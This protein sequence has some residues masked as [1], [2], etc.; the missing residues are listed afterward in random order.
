MEEKAGSA[1][2]GPG[3]IAGIPPVPAAAMAGFP[4]THHPPILPQYR[5]HPDLHNAAPLLCRR[6]V[7]ACRCCRNR[8]SSSEHPSV[9]LHGQPR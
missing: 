5:M 2:P 9:G 6:F 1:G 3:T 8:V 4:S 7:R